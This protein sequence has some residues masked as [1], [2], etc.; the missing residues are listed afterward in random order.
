MYGAMTR[1]RQKG[2]IILASTLTLLLLALA[3]RPGLG[4]HAN[5]QYIDYNAKCADLAPNGVKWDELKVAPVRDGNHSKGS[6]TVT[7][8][9][10]QS[11]EADVI[12]WSTNMGVDGVFVKGGPGG[13]FYRYNPPGSD[14]TS[15]HGLVAP[16]NENSGKH[17]KPGHMLFCTR[18]GQPLPSGTPTA[19]PLA[20]ATPTPSSPVT[21]APTAT[22]T[23]PATAT[24]TPSLTPSITPSVTS[25]G[26]PPTITVVLPTPTPS[27]TGTQAPP[28][29]ARIFAPYI[30]RDCTIPPGEPND[31]C[32]IAFGVQLDT[33]YE[34]YADDTH[35][36]YWFR[37]DAPAELTIHVQNFVPLDG[38]LAAYYGSNC[39][40]A[41]LLKNYGDPTLEKM[42]ALGQQPAGLYFI[43][44]SNDG[45]LNS[46]DPYRLF[47][48]T[49]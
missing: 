24:G 22:G 44:V 48:E 12:A 36:W 1:L 43:Y 45:D 21:V 46:S 11:D 33:L 14:A 18:S 8:D 6:L 9:V 40:D 19:S 30:C 49:R 13:H 28:F 31:A 37:L 39:K 20:T 41:D 3:S 29:E 17:Y 47:I 10:E 35:D 26:L 16:F 15:D 7:L 25:T 34:F 23:A 4:T 42:L 2:I 32:S 5:P 38:Q 27:A